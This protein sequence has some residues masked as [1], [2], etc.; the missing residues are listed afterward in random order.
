MSGFDKDWL[1]LREP[2]DLRSRARPLVEHLSRHLEGVT[3]PVIIDIG[4]GTV[5]PGAAFPE[6]FRPRPAGSCSTMIHCFWPRLNAGSAD[7]H[8]LFPPV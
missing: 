8:G 3:S 6:H 2:V 5:R 7:E 1:A 4:C